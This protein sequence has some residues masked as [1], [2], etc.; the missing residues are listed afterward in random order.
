MPVVL[1]PVPVIFPFPAF[2]TGLA[3]VPVELVPQSDR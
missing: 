2:F 1:V 3:L